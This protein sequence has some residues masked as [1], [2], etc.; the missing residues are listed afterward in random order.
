MHV[1][2]FIRQM[3]VNMAE[4]MTKKGAGSLAPRYADP[5]QALRSEM[6]QLFDSFLTRGFAAPRLFGGE[7]ETVLMPHLDVKENEAAILIE[8]ELPGLDEKQVELTLQDGILTITGEKK[9]GCKEDKNGYH[10]MERRYGS[11]KRSLRLPETV[12]QDKVEA[13][14]EKGVL[15]VTLPKKPDAVRQQKKIAIKAG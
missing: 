5:F 14:F 3:E 6:D 1:S 11:F 12:D 9:S 13:R 4:D 15:K 8:V 10:L 7:H 2:L